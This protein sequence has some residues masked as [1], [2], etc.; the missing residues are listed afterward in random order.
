MPGVVIGSAEPYAWPGGY[1]IGYVCDD[2]ELLCAGCVNDST[3]PVHVGGE[4]D[5]WR[6]EG[7]DVLYES[8]TGEECAHCTKVLIEADGE[9]CKAALVRRARDGAA[10]VAG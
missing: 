9:V 2:G 10:K 3:N 8:E 6:I 1:P 5:G 4:A 7:A